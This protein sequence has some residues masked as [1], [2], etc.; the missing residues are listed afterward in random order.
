MKQSSAVKQIVASSRA[1]Q[2]AGIPSFCTAHPE[3]LRAIFRAYKHTSE[4][5]LI[6]ATCNQ[7]NQDGGYT[8]MTPIDFRRFVHDLAGEAG[9]DAERIILGGDHLGPNPWK[10]L[11]SQDAMAKACALV[12]CFAEAGFTKIHLD[13]SMACADDHALSEEEMAARAAALCA[14]AENS[15]GNAELLYVIGTEVP[16]PGGETGMLDALAVTK[17]D[18]A[19]RTFELHQSAFIK[20]GLESALARVIGIVVQPGVDFGN[21]QIFAFDKNSAS[22]LA[23]AIHNIPGVVFEAHS[24][25]YQTARA[26]RDLVDSSFA[27]LKVGPELTAAYREA[28][29][30]MACIEEQLPLQVKSNIMAVIAAAM[31]HD[32]V[33]WQ[34]YVANDSRAELLKIFGLSD[35]IRYYWPRPEIQKALK[36]LSSN[37][38]LASG[39]TGLIAQ[40]ASLPERRELPLSQEIIQARVGAVVNKYRAAC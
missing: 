40:F 32:P 13:A 22:G 34:G 19:S 5:V 7:V 20:L 26:L 4:P 17:A 23:A 30:A 14:V 8:G 28:I 38:D 11:A 24:T 31:N 27:I 21:S 9:I 10:N 1:G 2:H 25:D 12:A 35:R 39:E 16:V 36:V 6:E 15:A 29:V 18:A 3:V 33:Y 37:I